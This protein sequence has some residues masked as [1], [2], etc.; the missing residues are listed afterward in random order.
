VNDES[1]LF[2]DWEMPQETYFED[3]QPLEIGQCVQYELTKAILTAVKNSCAIKEE[4]AYISEIYKNAVFSYRVNAPDKMLN[5]AIVSA[6]SDALRETGRVISKD[7]I[8]KT[9]SEFKT[10]TGERN[11]NREFDYDSLPISSINRVLCVED[12]DLLP[13]LS[14]KEF[15][16]FLSYFKSHGKSIH[17][18]FGDFS[19]YTA[20]LPGLMMDFD[21]ASNIRDFDARKIEIDEVGIIA[22]A[23]ETHGLSFTEGARAALAA[24]WAK[25]RST[26]LEE[27][28]HTAMENFIAKSEFSSSVQNGRR[29]LS[30]ESFAWVERGSTDSPSASGNMPVSLSKLEELVGMESVKANVKSFAAHAVVMKAKAATGM[31][32]DMMNL[33]FLFLGNPGT[34]K[35]TVA[36][37]FAQMLK[38]LG[39][40]K[41]GH[42]VTASRRTLIGEYTGQTAPIVTETFM[43]ALGG[44]LF[45]DEAYSLHNSDKMMDSYGRE[46]LDTLTLLMSEF[47][48]RIAVIFA[49]YEEEMN[50]MFEEINPGLKDRFVYR[51]IFEDYG[52]DD[53]WRIFED[54]VRTAGLA[55]E[56]GTDA[57]V[58]SEIARVSANKDR[59]FANARTIN[60]LF[61][62]L[63]NIQE[64][65]LASRIY[66]AEEVTKAELATFTTEDCERWVESNAIRYPTLSGR[67]IGFDVNR[68]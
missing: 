66:A 8:F 24:E 15:R 5:S 2:L 30:A 59:Q 51:F 26:Q 3:E 10:I 50:N 11:F 42:L 62:S 53:L 33:S 20:A 52:K 40:L 63:V 54:K 4:K 57:T 6:L 67:S 27:R 60:N 49:G 9:I 47:A 44:V 22:S 45:V 65:R 58:K 13:V 7:V 39:L 25:F 31:N 19:S 61:Q 41:R 12:F 18:F 32:A 23:L 14:S 48:G 1:S 34:G 37:I 68:D 35:T 17:F 21:M 36:R 28:L 38:E 29:V 16:A 56:S 64:T 43:S 55:L 46:A